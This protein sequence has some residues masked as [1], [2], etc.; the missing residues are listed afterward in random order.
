M[1]RQANGS[2]ADFFFLFFFFK[3]IEV[4]VSSSLGCVTLPWCT[5]RRLAEQVLRT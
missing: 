1:W 5:C 3:Y 4:N 2:D